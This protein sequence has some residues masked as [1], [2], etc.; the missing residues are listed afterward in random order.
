M[1]RRLLPCPHCNQPCISQLRK[2]ALGP[3]TTATCRSCGKK[4]S[5]PWSTVWMMLPAFGAVSIARAIGNL[6]LLLVVS[7]VSLPTVV[8][9]WWARA[10]LIKR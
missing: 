7:A 3:A 4:V 1:S 2:S 9:L 5:V 10:P 6:P 8:Y